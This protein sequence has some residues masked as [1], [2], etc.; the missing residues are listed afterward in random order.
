METESPIP[1]SY[2]NG[3]IV[4][5]RWVGLLIVLGNLF[6]LHKSVQAKLCKCVNVQD[7]YH[8]SIP[9]PN[10]LRKQLLKAHCLFVVVNPRCLQLQQLWSHFNYRSKS[11]KIKTAAYF[12]TMQSKNSLHSTHIRLGIPSAVD[13]IL[14]ASQRPCIIGLVCSLV[15][16]RDTE[17]ED[18]GQ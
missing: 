12:L 3:Q 1:S 15:L 13:L 9:T 10:F 4:P 16:L 18:Q 6:Q 5:Q 2:I 17:T 7:C 8:S 14:K 11:F